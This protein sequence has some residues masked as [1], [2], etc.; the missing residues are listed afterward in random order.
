MRRGHNCIKVLAVMTAW[1][2]LFCFAGQKAQA[3]NANDQKAG[4]VLFYNIYTSRSFN[5]AAVDTRISITNTS[6]DDDVYVHFYFVDAYS[7]QVADA[8]MFLTRNQT[9]RFLASD[10]DPDVNGYIVAVATNKSGLP[11]Q[12]NFLIGDE[13]VKQTLGPTS[14]STHSYQL[15]APAFAKINNQVPALLADG[16]ST[17]LVFDGGASASSYE[18]LPA[19]VAIDNFESQVSADT[20]LILY[21]PRNN[22]YLGGDFGG[23]IFIL[24]FD[25]LEHPFSS[26]MGLV[27][28]VQTRLTIIRN[29]NLRVAAGHSGWARFNGS[30]EN[31]T[32]PLLGSV[33]TASDFNGGHNLHYLSFL[34]S[35]TIVVPVIGIG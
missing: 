25:D 2:C 26:S 17:S 34:P 20:R 33:V 29:L 14:G 32:I 28:W 13:M 5:T 15:T 16:I 8:L 4:S 31:G 24:Y 35:Y 11:I 30:R 6:P 21:S 10:M 1:L 19:E 12:H 22:L 27:C 18:R 23:Q 7:C 9:A 3:Q